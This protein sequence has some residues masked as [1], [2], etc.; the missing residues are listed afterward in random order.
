MPLY[1]GAF[2]SAAFINYAASL[3]LSGFALYSLLPLFSSGRSE[4]FLPDELKTAF[5]KNR[6][7]DGEGFILRSRRGKIRIIPENGARVALLSEAGDISDASQL[8]YAARKYVDD[9]TER[10]TRKRSE[11]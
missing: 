7:N 1:D 2:A 10:N 6:E 4:A 3:S 11:K 8:I 5:L 9:Y